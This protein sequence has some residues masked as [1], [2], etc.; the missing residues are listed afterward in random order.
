MRK[1]GYLIINYNDFK[2]TE[3]LINNIKDYKVIDEIVIVDNN[4]TDD[5]KNK[6]SKIKLLS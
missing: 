5:S 4:S 2:T 3:K 1:I 6:L